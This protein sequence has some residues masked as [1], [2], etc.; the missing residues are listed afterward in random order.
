MREREYHHVTWQG[1]NDFCDRANAQ[2]FSLIPSLDTPRELVS[3]KGGEET[4]TVRTN[5]IPMRHVSQFATGP[6]SDD[7]VIAYLVR[8][9]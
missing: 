7:G 4:E 8:F 3:V 5:Q 6:I 9:P 2:A 1:P